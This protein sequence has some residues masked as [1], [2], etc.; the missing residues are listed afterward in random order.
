MLTLLLEVEVEVE[1]EVEAGRYISVT[2]PLPLPVVSLLLLSI[3]LFLL[4]GFDLLHPRYKSRMRG[5]QVVVHVVC[6]WVGH[7]CVL[8]SRIR[9]QTSDE[10]TH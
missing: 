1:V 5:V 3:V 9:M 8:L 4:V 6:K 10:Q 7:W 2:S